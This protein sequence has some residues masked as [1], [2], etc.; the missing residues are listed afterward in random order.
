MKNFRKMKRP[1]A[2]AALSLTLFQFSAQQAVA[3]GNYQQAQSYQVDQRQVQ[4]A[5][6]WA[7]IAA[8][9]AV[10]SAAVAA[11]EGA[12]NVGTIVGRAAYDLFGKQSNALA[13]DFERAQ[14]APA[15]FSEFDTPT[16]N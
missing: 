3:V 14:Y 9:V 12:Y 13:M 11:V 4:N 5:I 8:G 10:A 15:D 7:A 16:H 2:V 6:G 1:I